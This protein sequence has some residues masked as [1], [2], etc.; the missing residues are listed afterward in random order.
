MPAKGK[1]IKAGTNS[2][3]SLQDKLVATASRT[4]TRTRPKQSKRP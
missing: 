1:N 2:L 4:A 3:T